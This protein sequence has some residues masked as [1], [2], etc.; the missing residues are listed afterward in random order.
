MKNT[1]KDW[2]QRDTAI[3]KVTDELKTEIGNSIL[4]I[5]E[6]NKKVGVILYPTKFKPSPVQ[7]NAQMANKI[8]KK[9]YEVS[10]LIEIVEK[11]V[12]YANPKKPKK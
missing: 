5:I 11:L 1:L 2:K 10:K 12:P 9:Q 4:N 8:K 3:S 7:F 6:E